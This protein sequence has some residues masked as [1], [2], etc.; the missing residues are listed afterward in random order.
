MVNGL[1]HN[2]V[3]KDDITEI[4]RLLYA[5]VYVTVERLGMLKD[6]KGVSVRWI[7]PRGGSEG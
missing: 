4:Q 6:R 3:T 1:M 2:V 5:G 7:R